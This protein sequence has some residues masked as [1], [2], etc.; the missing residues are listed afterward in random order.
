VARPLHDLTRKANVWRWATQE[1]SAF[2]QLKNLV[3]SSPVLIFP[4]E[5]KPFVLEADSSD[6]ATGAVLSQEGDDGKL[7]PVGFMSRSLSDVERNYEIHD[8]EMLAIIRGLE[9]WRHYLEGARHKFEVFT[10]H[11]NLQYFRVAQ[12]LNRRQA[13]WS[14][15]LS[16]FDFT[17]SHKPGKTMLKVDSLSRR[18]DHGRGQNDNDNIVLLQPELFRIQA[19]TIADIHDV[20]D[21]FLERIRNTEDRDESVV[22]AIKELKNSAHSGVR[23]AEWEEE[24][25]VVLFRGRLY[26]PLDAQLRHDIVA[27]HHDTPV[28]GHPGRWK[29]HE[30]VGRNY[31]WPGM[32][33]YVAQYVASCDKCNRTKSFPSKPAGNLLP[34]RV[35]DRRWQIITMDMITQLPESQGYDSI[36]VV[37]DRL[38]KRMHAIPIHA[39]TDSLGLAKIFRDHIWRHH[40]LPEQVITDRGATFISTFMRDL[41]HLLGIQTSPSTAFHPQTDGQTERVNQEIE[42]YLR[43]FVN[44]R[45]DDWVECLPLA[46]F[47]YND[48]IHSSTR[49]SPFSLDTGQHPRLGVEPRRTSRVAEATNFATT[50]QHNLD[51][52]RACLQLAA[53]DMAHFYDAHRQ[54]APEYNVG[55]MVWLDSRNIK[56]T[57]PAKKLDDK[58]F[59]PFEIQTKINRNA[60]RLKLPPNFRQVHP[61]FHVVKLRHHTPNPFPER[62]TLPPPPPPDIVDGI[63]EFV[64]EEIVDS[65]LFR[66]K[67]Q[68]L[69]KWHGYPDSDRTWEP[70]ANCNNSPEAIANFYC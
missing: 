67:L 45:Q 65:R 55:D 21:H 70:A 22:K 53:D 20:S 50:I 57:R 2:E 27:G 37:V 15:Y 49:Q 46:E 42:Q 54:P 64:V 23:N 26:V 25:G 36:L 59:G 60:Y 58:W 61:V 4:S 62:P 51:E 12:K 16:R 40:G 24:D 47:C 66:G 56:T 1:Q 44:E 28:V 19:T 48:R 14:L 13:R 38:S 52:A 32:S 5:H 30:L 69:V 41:N 68:F 11:K 33:R 9:E 31:W 35:P 34:N 39:E 7:H 3:T 8:K 63:E 17:L 29:T 6:F 10:D 43:I 18:A